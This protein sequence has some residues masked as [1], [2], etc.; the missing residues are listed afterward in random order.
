[1][2]GNQN[3]RLC[4][5]HSVGIVVLKGLED[6]VLNFLRALGLAWAVGNFKLLWMDS[7]L[8]CHVV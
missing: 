3:L 1:V 4:S 6:R 8:R 7:F 2:C 5:F